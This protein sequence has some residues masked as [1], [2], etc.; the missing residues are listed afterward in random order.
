MSE[1]WVFV[2]FLHC[3]TTLWFCG[4]RN[5]YLLSY[6]DSGGLCNTV[7]AIHQ[8]TLVDR[9]LLRRVLGVSVHLRTKRFP[10]LNPLRNFWNTANHPGLF[11]VCFNRRPA[12]PSPEPS[13]DQQGARRQC[14]CF[15]GKGL[16]R[17]ALHHGRDRAAELVDDLR[18]KGTL[19]I[20]C[21]AMCG[22]LSCH[23]ISYFSLYW[24]FS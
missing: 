7:V 9:R 16:I 21:L 23:P 20:P 13:R 3:E 1:S 8:N 15:C 14:C 19:Q 18:T 17:A 10:F 5:N 24:F 22:C 6:F 11:P 12:R 2:L 4:D